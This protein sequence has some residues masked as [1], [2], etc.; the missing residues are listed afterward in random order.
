MKRNTI[1]TSLMLIALFAVVAFAQ[2][3]KSVAPPSITSVRDVDQPA[4]QPFFKN[5]STN[6]S[7]LVTV[8]AGKVL[9]IESVDGKVFS[10]PGDIAPITLY[11]IDYSVDPIVVKQVH[12]LAP[13]FQT[14]NGKTFYTH[15]ARFYVESRFHYV[16]GRTIN[17]TA[18]TLPSAAST[19]GSCSSGCTTNA[20]Y[21]P[22]TFGLRF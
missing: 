2:T 21:F 3:G 8:P 1:F 11:A 16:W 14:A 7:N 10:S 13:T 4:K 5:T 9:V 22:L 12:V 6:F 17:P 18:S 19:T 15:Q 20:A